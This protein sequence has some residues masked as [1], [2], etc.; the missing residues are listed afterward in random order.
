[1]SETCFIHMWLYYVEW[2]GPGGKVG[3][4]DQPNSRRQGILSFGEY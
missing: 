4:K 3:R 1:M 2:Q